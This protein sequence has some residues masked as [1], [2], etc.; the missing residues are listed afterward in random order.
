LEAGDE[1]LMTYLRENDTLFKTYLNTKSN[2]KY[3]DVMFNEVR[4][5]S[6]H[7]FDEVI[8]HW[9]DSLI[10]LTPK[11]SKATTKDN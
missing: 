6:A 4:Y 10:N 8:Q 5:V 1:N 2:A 7:Q 3:F 11:A 9:S